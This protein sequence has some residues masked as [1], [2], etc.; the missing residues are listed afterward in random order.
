MWIVVDKTDDTFD[1]FLLSGNTIVKKKYISFATNLNK[2]ATKYSS[3]ELVCPLS[4][5]NYSVIA[6]TLSILYFDQST[7]NIIDC[8]NYEIDKFIY[9]IL[10]DLQVYASAI[11]NLLL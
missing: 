1:V 10:A 3:T 9:W 8:K 5:K 7:G 2:F 6:N 11:M 4:G